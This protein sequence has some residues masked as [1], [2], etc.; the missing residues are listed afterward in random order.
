MSQFQ[1]PITIAQAMSYID[2]NYYLLPAFQREFVWKSDQIEKLFDSLMR[3]YPTSSML[4]WKVKGDTKTK[5]KFYKFINSFVLDASDHSVVNELYNTSNSNDF[6]AVLDGQQRLTAMRI[7]IYGSY[8]YHELRKSW[9]YSDNSFPSR[10]MYLNLSKTGGLDDDC[11]YFFSFQKDTDTKVA[12][13]Y[14]DSEGCLWIKVGA[15][16]PFH[17]SGEEISDYFSEVYLTKEQRKIVKL[18]DNTIFNDTAITFY[19]EDEQNPDKAVKIF[20]RI[21]SGGTFLSFSD[22]VFSLMVANWDKK[23]ARTEINDLIKTVGQKGFEI[24]KDYIVK[25]FLYLHHSSVKT[26][27]NSFSKDFCDIIE[28]KWEKIRGAILSTFDLLRSYGLTSFSLTSNN[29]TLPILYYLYHKNIYDDYTNKVAYKDEREE[30]KRWI[31]SAILRKTFGGQSDSTLQQTRRYFTDDIKTTFIKDSLP[32]NGDALNSCIKNLAPIDEELLEGILGTQKDNCYA[33]PILSLLYPHLD[34]KNNDF[35]KDHLHAE[36]LYDSLSEELKAKYPFK[37]Y[38]SI[39][40]LQMLDKNENESKGKME[41]A[42]WVDKVCPNPDARE[43]FLRIHIIPNVDLSLDNLENFFEQ[44][45]ILLKAKL[46]S[47][48]MGNIQSV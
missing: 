22:I 13:F 21:N 19:E 30:I 39:L 23:D 15:I 32:F 47:I 11:E 8:A 29:A 6:Y 27:I 1:M 26:E 36:D 12:D 31:L 2:S 24:G 9:N 16:V 42:D 7:G 14:T 20:T 3:K 4:F 41:L 48:L 5:W 45:R 25:A 43:A 35:H 10:H 44:R 38:N 46:T 40:N 18:L 33:F 17:K 34:Y 37:V 28:E